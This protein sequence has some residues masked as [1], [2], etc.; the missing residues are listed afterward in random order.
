MPQ[1]LPTPFASSAVC[2]SP[3]GSFVTARQ[4]WRKL[5]SKRSSR[6]ISYSSPAAHQKA[7]ATYPI[8]SWRSLVPPVSWPTVSPLSPA[9]LSASPP[10]T[11]SAEPNA[12]RFPLL[13]CP[14]FP[15]PPSS[16]FTNSSHPLFASWPAVARLLRQPCAR[17]FLSESI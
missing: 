6:P 5:F 4:P 12:V 10:Y 16:P 13:C 3:E 14:V 9:S 15:L 11:L 8:L 2:R 17:T 7:Q 1:C